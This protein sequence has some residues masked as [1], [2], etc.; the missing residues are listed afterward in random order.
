MNSSITTAS[1]GAANLQ[2]CKQQIEESMQIMDQ[3]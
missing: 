2:E 1:E 3:S